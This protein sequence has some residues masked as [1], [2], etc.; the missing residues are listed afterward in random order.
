VFE[1]ADDITPEVIDWL[2]SDDPVDYHYQ[3]DYS[4][5]AFFNTISRTYH[6]GVRTTLQ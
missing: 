3:G 6:E 5:E 4:A 2:K 1:S